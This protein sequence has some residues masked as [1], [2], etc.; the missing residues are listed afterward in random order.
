MVIMGGLPMDGLFTVV[1]AQ[2]IVVFCP[3]GSEGMGPCGPDFRLL[4]LVEF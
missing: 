4:G 1:T 3:V 2:G